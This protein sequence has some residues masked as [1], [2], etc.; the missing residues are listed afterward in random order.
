MSTILRLDPCRRFTFGITIENYDIR[1]WFLSRVALLKS[2]PFNFME[3][4]RL[5]FAQ[6]SP[7][8]FGV[9][10]F[11]EARNVGPTLPFFRVRLSL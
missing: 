11:V 2:E 6:M 1:I 7:C 10:S 4:W 5:L 9:L 3:V 8:S